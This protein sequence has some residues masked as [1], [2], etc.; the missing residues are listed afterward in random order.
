MGPGG[1]KAL[2]APDKSFRSPYGY[3]ACALL[4]PPLCP[5][6]PPLFP[7][8]PPRLYPAVALVMVGKSQGGGTPARVDERVDERVLLMRF[9][10]AN[11][12]GR[13][14]VKAG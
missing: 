8:Q 5:L 2:H 12:G 11:E 6:H 7:P 14:G 1:P 10:G 4:Y 3:L 9:D 13:G